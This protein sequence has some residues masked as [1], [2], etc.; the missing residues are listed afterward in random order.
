MDQPGTP[1][2][3]N[4][5]LPAPAPPQTFMASHVEVSNG[6]VKNGTSLPYVIETNK[7]GKDI[8]SYYSLGQAF[9]SAIFRQQKTFFQNLAR[10]W[11]M[12]EKI[13]V[14]YYDEKTS[15]D[16]HWGEAVQLQSLWEAV[17]SE[18]KS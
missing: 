15:C 14:R 1:E 11:N 4:N 12:W 16:S 2:T 5:A 6:F 13:C 9:Y 8:I 7:S 3:T 18:R 17:H 10:M